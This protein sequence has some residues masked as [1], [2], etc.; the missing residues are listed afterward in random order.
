MNI[1]K[2][3]FSGVKEIFGFGSDGPTTGADNVMKVAT[4]IGNW[5]DNNK[6]TDQEKATNDLKLT[7]HFGTFMK[8]S[9]DENSARSRARRDIS[10]LVIRWY[11]AMLTLSAILFK[12]DADWSK[13]VYKIATAEG[14]TYLVWGIG[15]FFFG[16]H[17]V[18]QV[19]KK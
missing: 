1:F 12:I 19:N 14:I 17:I 2:G 15:A 3:I 4:G 10:L 11:L 6:Y 18:R 16:A 5:I 9:V 13:Y 8:N 7:E